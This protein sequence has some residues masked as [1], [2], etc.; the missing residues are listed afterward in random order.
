MAFLLCHREEPRGRRGDLPFLFVHGRLPRRFAPRN[1]IK[2]SL[3]C[4]DWKKE[5][6][7]MA[8]LSW[9]NYDDEKLLAVRICD[10][11]LKIGATPLEGYIDELYG[12][13]D[14]K[15]V[16]FK[17]ECYLGDEWFCPDLEPVVSIP[18]YLAHPRLKQLE[19]KMILEVE[20]ETKAEFMKLLR[21]EVG[22][23]YNYAYRLYRKKLWKE[24]FGN[25][26]EEYP[27]S[28]VPRPYSRKY[29]RHLQNSYAQYHPDED[30]AETF[31][32]WLNP[33][34]DWRDEYK[35]W[36]VALSKLEYVD[37]LMSSIKDKEPPVPAGKKYWP[38][39]RLKRTL[40]FHY[41]K[42]R[43]ECA[44]DL[45]G[46]YNPDLKR[47]FRERCGEGD[48]EKAY[49]FIERYRRSVVA[50]VGMWTGKNRYLINKIVKSL[51]ETAKE[52]DLTRDGSEEETLLELTSYVNTMVMNY[53]FTGRLKQC[54]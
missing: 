11:G 23:A 24:H 14:S 53:L 10:L 51:L 15:G 19:K 43:R 16:K 13:L 45:P 31:A 30:F 42:K 2:L 38:V 33:A 9:E 40:D 54:P 41:K 39:E 28:Y 47:I 17:P 3:D 52:L 5:Y 4:G 6:G 34:V 44:E 29:V 35:N 37:Q 48:K 25:F 49:Q 50:S 22:H 20:G 36:K 12:E 27:E 21:H 1:D 26:S 18:F 8:G 46:F 7:C 32:V